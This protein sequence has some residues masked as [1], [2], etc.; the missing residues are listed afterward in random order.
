MGAG[1]YNHRAAGVR[2]RAVRWGEKGS[3]YRA[4][5]CPPGLSL[6]IGTARYPATQDI[7]RQA[8]EL[9]MGRRPVRL[10]ATFRWSELAS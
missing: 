10:P 5:C 3:K 6:P 7:S 4:L 9:S 8:W 2:E 1:G